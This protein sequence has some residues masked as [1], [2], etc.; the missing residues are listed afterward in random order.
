METKRDLLSLHETVAEFSGLEEKQCF[1]MTSLCPD[2]CGHGGTTAVFTILKYL[3]YEKP[4]KYGDEKSD[5]YYVRPKDPIESTGITPEVKIVL[6]AL[7]GGD[8]VL[9]SWNHDYVHKEG[10]SFPERPITKLLK[11]GKEE[12][13]KLGN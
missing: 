8:F 6:D 9:L 2:E 12:A 11:I 4:G 10:S 7:T 1:H 3:K 13:E 5:K